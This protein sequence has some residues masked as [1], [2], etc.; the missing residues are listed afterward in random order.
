MSPSKRPAD[1]M[2]S[3]SASDCV[4]TRVSA[5]LEERT[6]TTCLTRLAGP[7]APLSHLKSSGVRGAART[8]LAA[9]T[10]FSSSEDTSSPGRLTPL[11]STETSQLIETL[12]L[13]LV[14]SSSVPVFALMSHV[15][16]FDFPETTLSYNQSNYKLTTEL[17]HSG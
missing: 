1:S 13:Q 8:S 16:G 3:L 4:S 12:L 11:Q 17:R 9:I 6:K 7:L 15:F 5:D 10:R 2:G 14:P